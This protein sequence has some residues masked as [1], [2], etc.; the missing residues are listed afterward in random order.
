MPNLDDVT[1]GNYQ[2]AA[3]NIANSYIPYYRNIAAKYTDTKQGVGKVVQEQQV[4]C[5]KAL[6]LLARVEGRGATPITRKELKELNKLLENIKE[7][8]VQVSAWIKEG[9]S[10]SEDSEKAIK[11]LALT[12]EDMKAVAGDSEKTKA[13]RLTGYALKHPFY[14]TILSR[15]AWKASSYGGGLLGAMGNLAGPF[16]SLLGPAAGLGA[17]AGYGILKTPKALRSVYRGGKNVLGAMVSPLKTVGNEFRGGEKES[18]G[19]GFSGSSGLFNSFGTSAASSGQPFRTLSR[20]K[21]EEATDSLFYFFNKRAYRAGWTRDVLKAL[22]G[23]GGKGETGLFST[24][25]D[26]FNVGA[27][28]A[29]GSGL[30]K[31]FGKIGAVT[32][33]ATTAY[34]TGTLL[35]KKIEKPVLSWLEKLFGG[36]LGYPY[37]D[38][39]TKTEKTKTEKAGGIL[40]TIYQVLTASPDELREMHGR[41]WPKSRSKKGLKFPSLEEF[42]GTNPK[43]G[44]PWTETERIK[45]IEEKKKAP[46]LSIDEMIRQGIPRNKWPDSLTNEVGLKDEL[47]KVNENLDKVDKSIQTQPQQGSPSEPATRDTMGLRSDNED[48]LMN[49]IATGGFRYA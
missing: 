49:I 31:F 6:S 48:P 28:I 5:K 23:K 18:G 9:L 32:L 39:K 22:G 4:R 13:E 30:L 16:E 25:K 40:R 41:N 34:F 24:I 42:L 44:F 29:I 12:P 21:K 36:I 1:I 11:N 33:T 26:W 38:P 7:S 37:G 19:T 27:G 2:I 45:Q 35:W 14:A 15:L 46:S 10:V 17:L 8:H 43:T 47:K 20:R 3:M